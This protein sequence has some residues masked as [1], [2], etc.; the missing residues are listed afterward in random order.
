M[1]LNVLTSTTDSLTA[2][3]AALAKSLLSLRLRY[4][5]LDPRA[6]DRA[7]AAGFITVT[8]DGHLS[9]CLGSKTLL[10]YFM[11]RLLCGDH[12]RY[13]ARRDYSVWLWGKRRFP[14][15]EL[16]Q[17]FGEISLGDIRKKRHN[18]P[19]P[20]DHDIVDQLFSADDF[21]TK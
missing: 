4:R 17:L 14:G 15:K 1:G 20:A 11:G 16:S 13:I 18:R 5:M 6:F 19:L 21:E 7:V 12:G 3:V 2:E 8:D 9:W 10:T